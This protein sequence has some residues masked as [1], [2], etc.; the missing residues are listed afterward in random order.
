MSD[1]DYLAEARERIVSRN[2]ADSFAAVATATDIRR[3]ADAFERI[4]THLTLPQGTEHVTGETTGTVT[5]SPS[6]AEHV[7]RICRTCGECHQFGHPDPDAPALVALD[8]AES[9]AVTAL[10][11]WRKVDRLY[12]P[13]APEAWPALLRLR[14]VADRLGLAR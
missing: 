1:T 5:S 9:E 12:P 2:A 6:P 10:T 13:E 7:C 8:H 4:A 11:E 3:L 14:D